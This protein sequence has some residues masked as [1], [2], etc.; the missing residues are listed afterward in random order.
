MNDHTVESLAAKIAEIEAVG[1]GRSRRPRSR[2]EDAVAS[3][4]TQLDGERA[5][6]ADGVAPS[7]IDPDPR[8]DA[9]LPSRDVDEVRGASLTDLSGQVAHDEALGVAPDG[10][11]LD[12]AEDAESR[13]RRKKAKPAQ[14]AFSEVEP[15]QRAIELALKLVSQR[16][17][18]AKQVREKLAAKDCEPAEI[19][20]AIAEL[21]RQGFLDDRRFAKLFA[22]DKR[23]LQGW[24]A[25]RI[26]LELGRAGV[27]R[28]VID[29]L[30]ADDEAELDAPSEL[31]VALAVL[32]RKQPDLGDPKVKQRTAAML[33]RRGIASSTVF[34][35]LREHARLRHQ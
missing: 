19:R 18:T 30:F 21:E 8:I 13:G 15:Y 2:V 35:A 11:P 5:V 29:D 23:R 34:A 17:R 32:A 1:T 27:A 24:G 12:P 31:D 28:G 9:S 16:E 20:G 10:R 3:S 26:R 25:R 6:V 33:A 4:Q 22:E 7:G 14:L